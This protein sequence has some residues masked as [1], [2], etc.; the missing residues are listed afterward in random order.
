MRDSHQEP[1]P[2]AARDGAGWVRRWVMIGA[3]QC[4][5]DDWPLH[6][7]TAPS[8]RDGGPLAARA[9]DIGR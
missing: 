7:G 8:G 2:Y 6:A 9:R 3:M 5:A 1:Q 4:R